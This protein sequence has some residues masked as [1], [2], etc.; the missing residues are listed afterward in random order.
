MGCSLA[1]RSLR[2]RP[3]RPWAW[4]V[5]FRYP[6]ALETPV[7][8]VEPWVWNG[9][10]ISWRVA[11]RAWS[12]WVLEWKRERMRGSMLGMVSDSMRMPIFIPERESGVG[13]ERRLL[14]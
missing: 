1:E 8:I 12:F 2:M 3:R 5:R 10:L 13:C 14:W 11:P 4:P 7:Q 6:P 9:T